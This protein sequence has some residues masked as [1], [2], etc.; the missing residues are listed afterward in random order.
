[1]PIDPDYAILEIAVPEKFV[2][3]T[4]KQRDLH[5]RMG[6]WAVGVKNALTGELVMLPDGDFPFQPDQMVLVVENTKNSI[7][8]EQNSERLRTMSS[9]ERSP[10]KPVAGR[11]ATSCSEVAALATSGDSCHG[12]CFFGTCDHVV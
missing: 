9:C 4:L 3:K 11:P 1:L 2:G 12:I 5:R 10:L 7:V 6:A 8:C